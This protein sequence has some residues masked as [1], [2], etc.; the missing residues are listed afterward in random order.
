MDKVT[1][2]IF[3][4]S[5]PHTVTEE[6]LRKKVGEHGGVTALFYMM[7]Q[8]AGDRGWAFVTYETVMDAQAA[9]DAMNDKKIF[10]GSSTPIEA[11]FA[12]QKPTPKSA[13]FQD[14]P[15][16]ATGAASATTSSVWQ[17]FFTPEGHA[18]Y[19]NTTTGVT[20]WEKPEDFETASAPPPPVSASP[21]GFVNNTVT[22]FGPPGSNVFVA[23][24]PT[25]WNDIDLIQHFQHFGNILSA[26]IQ[27]CSQGN[28]RGFGFVS[29]DNPQAAV[30]AIRGMN[31]FSS[32]GK[33]LRVCL[34]KGE[35]QYLT[36]AMQAQIAGFVDERRPRH[37]MRPY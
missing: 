19:Y 5:I 16:S 26:R 15:A 13:V 24:I 25:D 11:R 32:G 6:E 28:S 37:T 2:K 3:V 14:K 1:R 4:G 8:T 22:R 10:E 31:G 35:E 12:N 27:R 33:F 29:F 7:D 30:N 21:V 18:Y 20:Q 23:S 9:I 34:K 36:P 17:Q